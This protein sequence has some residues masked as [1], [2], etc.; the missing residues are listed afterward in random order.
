MKRRTAIQALMALLV[1]SRKQET[2]Q[3]QS[4]AIS[5]EYEFDETGARQT[6]KFHD[7]SEITTQVAGMP[8]SA[9]LMEA[10]RLQL[11][12]CRHLS[13]WVTSR[14]VRGRAIWLAR[15]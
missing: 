2:H 4:A 7:G 3:V 12:Q 1:P 6:V 15:N 13:E 10:E 5:M 9:L 14:G 11:G 8:L